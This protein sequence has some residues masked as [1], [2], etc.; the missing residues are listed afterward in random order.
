MFLAIFSGLTYGQ[1]DRFL[2]T[3][4]IKNMGKTLFYRYQACYFVPAIRDLFSQSLVTTRQQILA[5]GIQFATT[6]LRLF[7]I[8]GIIKTNI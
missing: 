7:K 6:K 1:V 3:V 4:G 2:S 8:F 5:S